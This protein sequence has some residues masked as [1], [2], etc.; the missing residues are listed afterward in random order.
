MVKQFIKGIMGKKQEEQKQENK[1]IPDELP[2]LAE[3]AA[4][5][6]NK[7]TEEKNNEPEDKD[8]KEKEKEQKEE[9]K[10]ENQREDEPEPA[11]DELQPIDEKTIDEPEE[12]EEQAE[13]KKEQKEEPEK[14]QEKSSGFFSNIL[15]ITKKQGIKKDFLEKDLYKGMKEYHALSNE[16]SIKP[17]SKKE[18]EEKISKNLDE[19]KKL[20]QEWQNQK[21]I[22]EKNK[23]NLAEK[24]KNIKEKV[25][26][27]RPLLKKIK[28]FEDVPVGKY[29]R[30]YDG[31]IAKNVLE[32]LN[33]L[34]VMDDNVFK[35]HLNNNK[36]DFS[37][38]ISKAVN[39]K[40]LAAEVRKAKTR[41]EMIS[42]LEGFSS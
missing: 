35:K 42:I 9:P 28:F 15:K 18:I 25:E 8:N 20:E 26:H 39:D 16:E 31:I 12:K 37:L 2:P 7:E 38:W 40:E 36:N 3:D 5:E 24:E 27:L 30:S 32:L 33:I 11:P 23:K 29:F 14:E 34:K 4:K 1:D 13:E 19:L 41:K 22:I 21:E 17:V 10:E 6:D